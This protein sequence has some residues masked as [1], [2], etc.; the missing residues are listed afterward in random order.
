M[1]VR[2]IHFG[3]F[4]IYWQSRTTCIIRIQIK[5]PNSL[6]LYIIAKLHVLPRGIHVV[7][8]PGPK[9]KKVELVSY[10]RKRPPRD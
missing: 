7:L 4:R 9:V 10:G 6:A 1:A 5:N 2:E 8:T 3:V